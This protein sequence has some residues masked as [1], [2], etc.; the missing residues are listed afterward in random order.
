MVPKIWST[1]ASISSTYKKD[2]IKGD[3]FLCD[4][5]AYLGGL[6][7]SLY[8]GLYPET[9][10][11]S[12]ALTSLAVELFSRFDMHESLDRLRMDRAAEVSRE[13][14]ISPCS[15]MLALIYLDRLRT[16]NPAYLSSLSSS[17][18]F[19]VSV[20]VASKFLHDDGEDDAVYNDEWAASA[21]I[22]ISELNQLERDFLAA[23]D[24]KLYVD[25]QGFADILTSIEEEVACREGKKRGWLTFTDLNILA[26]EAVLTESWNVLAAEVIT[27]SLACIT[28][29]VASV[30]TLIGSALLVSH[31]PVHAPSTALVSVDLST[32]TTTTMDSLTD[33]R[34]ISDSVGDDSRLNLETALNNLMNDT[35]PELTSDLTA[36]LGLGLGGI[37]FWTHVDSQEVTR[38]HYTDK[39][40]DVWTTFFRES[41]F[42]T[43]PDMS[44]WLNVYPFDSGLRW[45]G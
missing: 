8:Y 30:L 5:E 33:T 31:L 43:K 41:P 35:V 17:K 1:L 36:R 24:W 29:Y 34:L 20:L 44:R 16:N 19:L 32:S 38:D 22:D 21:D 40:V 42:Q 25:D 13:A 18:I 45:A 14:C 26:N 3:T 27:V 4:Y 39:P 37:P 7:K 15:L 10:R 9:E 2:L 6:E 23:I 28:A 11:P 12:L